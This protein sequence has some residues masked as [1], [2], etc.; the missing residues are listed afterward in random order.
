[1]DG[2]SYKGNACPI[3]RVEGTDHHGENLS[4]SQEQ[5][6]DTESIKSRQLV[7]IYHW[8]SYPMR[9]FNSSSEF[10]EITILMC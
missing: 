7:C 8:N 4:R 10:K 1:M 3:G 2:F 6:D 5:C 9:I